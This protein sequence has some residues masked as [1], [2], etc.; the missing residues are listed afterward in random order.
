MG[1]NDK[2]DQVDDYN[3]VRKN[4]YEILKGGLEIVP[5]LAELCKE[6]EHPRAYEVYFKAL[7]DLADVNDK[8]LDHQRKKQVIDREA[9][10]DQKQLENEG[11][12]VLS[13]E[14]FLKRIEDARRKDDDVTDAEFTEIED[15]ETTSEE[16]Q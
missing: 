1:S 16:G 9:P 11:Q 14:D 6:A 8:L 10:A 5:E 4:Y 13:T 2:L 3:F 7:K 12:A 15:D